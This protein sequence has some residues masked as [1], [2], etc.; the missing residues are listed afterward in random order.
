MRRGAGG[1]TDCRRLDPG[2]DLLRLAKQHHA[3]TLRMVITA[4]SDIDP[5][6]KA[7][8]EGLVARYIIKPFDH[9]DLLAR[10]DR[11][12]KRRTEHRLPG[13]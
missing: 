1:C 10:I 12:F 11:A 9:E 2:L 5:I 8:N 7:I 3:Q 4:F 13:S 6:L